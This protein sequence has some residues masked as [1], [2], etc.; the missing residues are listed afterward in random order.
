MDGHSG[1]N[2]REVD[3]HQ[4][5]RIGCQYPYLHA[6]KRSWLYI[7]LWKMGGP[8]M[9]AERRGCL[10]NRALSK[11]AAPQGITIYA[12]LPVGE[13]RIN[14]LDARQTCSKPG[15]GSGGS[16]GERFVE[17][18]GRMWRPSFWTGEVGYIWVA[19]HHSRFQLP[20]SHYILCTNPTSNSHVHQASRTGVVGSE[21]LIGSFG[22]TQDTG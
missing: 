10:P 17:E 3:G 5:L 9:A 15:W 20:R 12:K 21:S 19:P 8:R 4:W 18:V 7:L 1:R 6:T 22:G 11:S 16:C 14:V 2:D 13:R